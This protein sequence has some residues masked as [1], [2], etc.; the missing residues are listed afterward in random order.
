MREKK[1]TSWPWLKWGLVFGCTLLFIGIFGYCSDY[2]VNKDGH[3]TQ[4]R[5]ENQK[6]NPIQKD[7]RNY[8]E[9]NLNLKTSDAKT[10]L[11]S[12]KY[13]LTKTMTLYQ[14][15]THL[16]CT[17]SDLRKL[18]VGLKHKLTSYKVTKGKVITIPTKTTLQ[19]F[20]LEVLN[21][22]NKERTRVGLKPLHGDYSNLNKSAKEKSADMN[23]SNYFSHNSPTYGSPFDMMKKF[24]VIYKSA[25]ENIA[26]GQ[27]TPA[28]VVKAWMNSP[29]HR[30]NILNAQFTHIGVGYHKGNGEYWTQQFI[31]K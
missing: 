21:L 25:G 5:R 15:A 10:S 14:L 28:E 12:N 11:S 29:G 7:K 26:K 9:R 8:I 4:I 3:V 13:R 22:T 6:K 16:K 30:Q 17:V 20:E 2:R 31:A 1:E 24:G 18:N 27:K 19:G 23:K